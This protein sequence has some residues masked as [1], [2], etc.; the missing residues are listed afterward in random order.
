MTDERSAMSNNGGFDE[1]IGPEPKPLYSKDLEMSILAAVL[2]MPDSAEEHP[3]E[4]EDFYDKRHQIIWSAFSEIQAKNETPDYP[5]MVDLLDRKGELETIGGAAYLTGLYGSFFT[6]AGL[7]HNVATLK[8]YRTRRTIVAQASWMASKAFNFEIEPGYIQ[9]QVIMAMSGI[10]TFNM[11]SRHIGEVLAEVMDDATEAAKNPKQV[12]GVET[13]FYDFDKATGGI[14]VDEG[15]VIYIAGE[16][17][18]GKSIL[19]NQMGLQLSEHVPVWLVSLEMKDKRL[20]Q[21]LVS[22]HGEFPTRNLKSGMMDDKEWNQLVKSS[23]IISDRSI[24]I[25]D[26]RG[27]TLSQFRAEATRLKRMFGI[28][29]IVLDYLYLLAGYEDLL[30][31]PRT[32]VLSSGI[33]TIANQLGVGIISVNSVVKEGMKGYSASMADLRGSGQLIHDA[34]IVAFLSKKLKTLTD[35]EDERYKDLRLR[36][37]TFKKF[38]DGDLKDNYEISLGLTA[39]YPKFVNLSTSTPPLDLSNVTPPTRTEKYKQKGME[40]F[41]D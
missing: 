9:D 12:W 30:M 31:T 29:V 4:K 3:I 21:R 15:E 41:I 26:H 27:M 25:W 32:E 37:L 10:Q 35:Y 14:Q 20:V 24:H 38:R 13:G 1:I 8:D 34:D 6:D 11:R 40:R 23:N 2:I 5:G 19:C 18:V 33:M 7:E 36:G 17:G 28:K 16:P 39:G 22:A